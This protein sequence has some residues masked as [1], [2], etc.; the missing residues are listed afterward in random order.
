M[1]ANAVIAKQSIAN[2]K[3]EYLFTIFLGS[4]HGLL[5]TIN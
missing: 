4:G 2:P 5:R 3:N 1:N